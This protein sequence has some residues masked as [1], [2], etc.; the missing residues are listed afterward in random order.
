MTKRRITGLFV[1][2]ALA[3]VAGIALALVSAVLAIASGAVG[4]GGGDG[5]T[6]DGEAVAD[7]LVWW[8]AA[9]LLLGG[10]T[11]VAIASWVG[12]LFNTANL[13]DKTWF[14]LLLVLGL[15]SFGWVAMIAYVFA[16]PDATR[17]EPL[18]GGAPS[19]APG[20]TNPLAG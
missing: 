11:V 5:I 3:F 15:A 17:R 13:D 20:G 18:A 14:V 10:G 6:V 16:G 12:A 4:I 2:A 8:F 1:A 9:A 7:M 19:A